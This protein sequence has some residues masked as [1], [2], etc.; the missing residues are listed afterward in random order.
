MRVIEPHS[1]LLSVVLSLGAL[2]PQIHAFACPNQATVPSYFRSHTT[3][4]GLPSL[5]TWRARHG[6]QATVNPCAE[7]MYIVF[8][9]ATCV[10]IAQAALS[11]V[12]WTL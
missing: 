11:G 7:T 5:I 3:E 4:D 2:L 8:R 9:G 12:L 10:T 1:Q 6:R